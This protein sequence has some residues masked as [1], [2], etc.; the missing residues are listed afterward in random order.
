M[1]SI[2]R[3]LMSMKRERIFSF[4]DRR[5]YNYL[6]QRGIKFVGDGTENV[7][8]CYMYLVAKGFERVNQTSFTNF[9][10]SLNSSTFQI[11]FVLEN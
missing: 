10:T 3:M 5:Y 8:Y 6:T 9:T 2:L 1:M 7:V 4:Y 11:E